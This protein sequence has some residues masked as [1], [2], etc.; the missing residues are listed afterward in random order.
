MS[1]V[2]VI[3]DLHFGHKNIANFR[4]M[5]EFDD[6]KSHR[7]WVI[8]NWNRKITKRDKVIVLGDACFTEEALEGI[9]R[10]NGNKVL[11]HGN[12]DT[13]GASKYLTVFSDV[14]GMSRNKA[15]WLTHAPIH[16]DELSGK[17]NLHGHVHS[18][19]INDRRYRNLS[20]ENVIGYA[21][22]LLYEVVQCP[23]KVLMSVGKAYDK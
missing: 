9:S 17:L 6:E 21:P 5:A 1:N 20:L 3:A 7:E 4:R 14:L 12:H 23:E 11:I 19:T 18:A 2:Y 16:P 22:V 8:N 15:C 10:L 13:L